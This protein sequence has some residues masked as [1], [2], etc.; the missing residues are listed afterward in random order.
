M[1]RTTADRHTLHRVA[2]AA[3]P[4]LT[5]AAM[6]ADLTPQSGA[7]A[8]LLTA[9]REQPDRWLLTCSLFLVA[10]LAWA[11]GGIGLRRIVGARSCLVAVGGALLAA[12]GVALALIDAAGYYLSG[13]ARSGA[14]V[15]QQVTAVEHVESTGPLIALEVIHVA[16]WTLGLVL[17]S[18]G[19]LRSGTVARWV[20]ATVV[21]S[22][23]GV[24]AFTG[25]VPLW[26]A[27]AVQVVALTALAASLPVEAPHAVG[28]PAL[29]DQ[30][31]S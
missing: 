27:L 16:G 15:E 22:L 10:G 21:L 4:A 24:V 23:V 6:L 8:E 1:P 19:L 26:L 5:G 7:T 9:V 12:G 3:A 28:T 25:G 31:T 2:L 20:P 18:V 30:A 29:A 13:I 17:V 14:T 11:L